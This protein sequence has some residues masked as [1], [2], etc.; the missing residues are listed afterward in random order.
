M[1]EYII[2]TQKL[3][4]FCEHPMLGGS[5]N[6]QTQSLNK[7]CYR[8]IYIT[9]ESRTLHSVSFYGVLGASFEGFCVSMCM[10]VCVVCFCWLT[11][12]GPKNANRLYTYTGMM[13]INNNGLRRIFCGV[14]WLGG[15]AMENRHKVPGVWWFVQIDGDHSIYGQSL[16]EVGAWTHKNPFGIRVECQ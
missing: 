14:L 5:P 8:L 16:M 10:C 6:S 7:Q 13:R 12:F 3:C 15:R 4:V 9:R 2:F 1:V 11:G